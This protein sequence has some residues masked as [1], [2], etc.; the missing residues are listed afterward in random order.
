MNLSARPVIGVCT[1]YAAGCCAAIWLGLQAFPAFLVLVGAVAASFL[2]SRRAFTWPLLF[3]LA[4]LVGVMRTGLALTPPPGDVSRLCESGTPVTLSGYIA[5]EPARKPYRVT[6]VMQCQSE[7]GLPSTAGVE[8]RLLLTVPDYVLNSIPDSHLEYGQRLI[9]RGVVRT[10]PGPRQGDDFSYR[11]YLARQG[12]FCTLWV[13]NPESISVLPIEG[14]PLVYRLASHSRDWLADVFTSRMP[15]R[16]AG[17]VSGMLLGDYGLVDSALIED[18]T[19]TGTL[20]LL[21]ASGFNCG[22][23]VLVLWAGVFRV[24]PLPRRLALAIVIA[25]VLFYVLMVGGKPS[26]LRAGIGATLFLTALFLG[27]PA[28]LVTVLFS[29]ALILLV[30]NPAS[31]ADVGF[32]LSF[33]AVAAIL[34]AVPAL[35]SVL[36]L[37]GSRFSL[38]DLKPARLPKALARHSMAAAIVTSAATIGTL[39]VIAQ[40]FNRVSLVSLP[41]NVAVALLAVILFISGVLLAAFFWVPVLGWALTLFVTGVALLVDVIVTWFSSLP[42]AE[43]SCPSPGPLVIVCFYAVVWAAVR[44]L[45]SSSVPDAHSF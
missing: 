8:G 30:L 26:I 39:P 33:A 34:V 1:A 41:A 23:I 36:G 20:H 35:E 9:V 13:S 40:Y 12:I 32:Q 15:Q 28:R 4:A 2:Y 19:R 18:F 3:A 37:S 16:Q 17:L 31:I 27:R 24:A 5:S 7:R 10:P 45:Q 22:L 6:L 38:H 43:A 25:A 14:G 21:A 44:W 42:W 29:T 11:D